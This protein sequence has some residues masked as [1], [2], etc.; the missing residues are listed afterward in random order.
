[1]SFTRNAKIV[2]ASALLLSTLTL[3]SPA[4][5]TATPRLPEARLAAP[6]PGAR[7]IRTGTATA[8]TGT[9]NFISDRSALTAYAGY[10][11]DLMKLTSSGQSAV[12][13]FITNVSSQ[14]KSALAPLAQG[15]AVNAV[16]V[17]RTLKLLGREMGDDLSIAY[18]A[19]AS[20]DFTNLTSTLSHL[21]WTRF[22]GAA[23]ALKRFVSTETALL[24][25]TPSNLCQ[26][27]LYAATTPTVVPPGTKTFVKSYAH[28]AAAADDALQ[29]LLRVLQT[30][31]MT[32]EKSLLSRISSMANAFSSAS[33]SELMQSGSLLA[34]ALEN[35]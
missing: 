33:R 19:V 5:A 27:A 18:Y 23:A 22:S 35:T 30:Y 32:G 9:L 34:A 17:Q 21:R 31:E 3:S 4:A 20:P 7:A 2:T 26:D 1:M 29:N 6:V 25:I 13:A 12:N 24:S 16:K 11:D 10:L 28:T 14:C 8:G 15:T